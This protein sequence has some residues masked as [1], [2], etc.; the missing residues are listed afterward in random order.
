M[1]I[2]TWNINGIRAAARKGLAHHIQRLAP[3]IVLLQE[4]RATPDQL[5]TEFVSPQGWHMHWHPARKPGYS[6]TAIWSR[7]PMRIEHVGLAGPE[8][9]DEGRLVMA[10]IERLR[11]ASLYLP[12]GSSGEHRQ[13]E[14]DRWLAEFMPWASQ[15]LS[16]RTPT[17]IG[18]D[19]NIAHT[20][21]DIYYA[22]ANENT[23][24]FLPH[25]RAWFSSFLEA[26]W[27][28]FVRNAAGEIDGPY[29]WWSTRGQARALDRGWRIDYIVG[30]RAAEK[31]ITAAHIDRQG[32]L[33]VSDHAPVIVDLDG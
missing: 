12:S 16:S 28:D 8:S 31:R 25:E 19:F 22:K 20:P 5:P 27:R 30:N 9:D 26:G 15:F 3:D 18:G 32:G 17:L 6:G 1:R 10:R 13:A 21:R 4:V 23:S 11:I 7:M 24:G 14:K 2:L 33:E 29:S